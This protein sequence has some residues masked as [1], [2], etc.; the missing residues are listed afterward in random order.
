M[1]LEW[2]CHRLLCVRVTRPSS[3]ALSIAPQTQE[4][5]LASG[6][7][8]GEAGT[9][10]GFVGVGKHFIAVSTHLSRGHLDFT[11]SVHCGDLLPYGTSFIMGLWF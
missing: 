4:A 1:K 10:K 6:L 9:Q 11:F 5:L 3:P 8:Q 7:G 2:L